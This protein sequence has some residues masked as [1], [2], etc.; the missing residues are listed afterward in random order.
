MRQIPDLKIR[1]KF[2]IQCNDARKAISL[3]NSLKPDNINFP[4]DLQME[5]ELDKSSVIIDLTF[6]LKDQ[7]NNISNINTLLNTIEE[8]MEHV[9]V[10]KEVIDKHD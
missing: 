4:K 7:G 8:L 10:V 1:T 2:G 9:G 6:L 5:M 3:Y